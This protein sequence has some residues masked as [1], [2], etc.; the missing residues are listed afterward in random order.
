M[1]L[2]DFRKVEFVVED[3][4]NAAG[5][6]AISIYVNGTLYGTQ[7]GRNAFAANDNGCRMTI[8]S[9]GTPGADDYCLVKSIVYEPAE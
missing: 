6:L 1:P 3:D 2:A 4:P 9:T 8:E 7:A 5:K